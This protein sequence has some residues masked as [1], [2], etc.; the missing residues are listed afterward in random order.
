MKTTLLFILATLILFS[1]SGGLTI[2]KVKTK[3]DEFD[4]YTH[5]W[6]VGNEL[7]S[8]TMSFLSDVYGS[9][10]KSVELN[11]G[12][13]ETNNG[14]KSYSL[15]VEYEDSHWMFISSGESLVMLIDGERLGLYTN[16]EN[17][18]RDT[19]IFKKVTVWEHA[20]YTIDKET[21]RKIAF[22]KNIKIKV[23]G[24]RQNYEKELLDENIR[25]FK[26]FYE[27]YVQ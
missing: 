2:Y 26:R 10:S 20:T 5:H 4:G 17:I 9:G 13:I 15:S 14:I 3:V 12:V 24:E 1:C 23:R 16:D 7:E 22:A 27:E 25:N 11:A 8:S 6:M 19:F 21:L 18:S